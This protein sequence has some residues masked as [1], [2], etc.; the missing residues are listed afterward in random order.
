MKFIYSRTNKIS[1]N[2]IIFDKIEESFYME[3][4]IETNFSVML[5][6]AY[7]GVDINLIDMQIYGA[8]GLCPM[9]IWIKEKLKLPKY[10]INGNVKINSNEELKAGIG[11]AMFEKLPIYFDEEKK[12]ICIGEKDFLEYTDSIKFIENAIICLKCNEF[13]ALWINIIND[14]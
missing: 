11:V 1:I 7:L 10:V 13:K 3:R 12:W 9:N 4:S 6:C 14:N 8:S 5:G 2:R